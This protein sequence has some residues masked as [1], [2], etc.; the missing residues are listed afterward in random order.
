MKESRFERIKREKRELEKEKEKDEPEKPNPY[1]W[2]V[3]EK[4]E[5]ELTNNRMFRIL[6]KRI[7]SS[8]PF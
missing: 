1:K 7:G 4:P 8:C 5:N 6:W 2:A 3:N